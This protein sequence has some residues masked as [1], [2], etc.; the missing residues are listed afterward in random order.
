MSAF[1]NS[2]RK[3]TED[4]YFFCTRR[5]KI[6]FQQSFAGYIQPRAGRLHDL[7]RIFGS[8]DNR[9]NAADGEIRKALARNRRGD[10]RC[11]V[12]CRQMHLMPAFGQR[13]GHRSSDGRLADAA[14]THG[15][16]HAVPRPG[17]IVNQRRQR[18]RKLRT[19]HWNIAWTR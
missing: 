18:L 7:T 8:F 1:R 11:R 10:M 14:F 2:I 19:I 6:F 3:C 4:G 9:I 17:Q 15:K 16:N 13:H 5:A 12:G